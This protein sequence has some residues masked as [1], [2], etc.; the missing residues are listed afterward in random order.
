[1]E[2]KLREEDENSGGPPKLPE[3]SLRIYCGKAPTAASALALFRKPKLDLS[4][5]HVTLE[6]QALKNSLD[7]LFPFPFTLFNVREPTMYCLKPL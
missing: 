1:M 3:T 4:L 7:M 5:S 2:C 6:W